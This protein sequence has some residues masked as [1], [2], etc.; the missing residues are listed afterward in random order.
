LVTS[1]NAGRPTTTK[2]FAFMPQTNDEPDWLN[3]DRDQMTEQ[4]PNPLKFAEIQASATSTV[5]STSE[6]SANA[7]RSL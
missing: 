1:A 6:V 5:A 7:E 3:F 2:S 4:C